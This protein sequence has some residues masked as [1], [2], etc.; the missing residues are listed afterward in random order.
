MF[1][2]CA[3]SWKDRVSKQIIL[4]HEKFCNVIAKCDFFKENIRSFLKSLGKWEK[5]RLLYDTRIIKRTGW[6]SFKFLAGNTIHKRG[7]CFSFLDKHQ[8]N[9]IHLFCQSSSFPLSQ[10]W[11]WL[12][13]NS[14]SFFGMLF[15]FAT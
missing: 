10:T 12:S 11:Q 14:K 5:G 1:S 6:N 8:P 9:V 15:L 7:S 13:R 4:F 3:N 2:R